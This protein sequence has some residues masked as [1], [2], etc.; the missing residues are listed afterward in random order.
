MEQLEENLAIAENEQIP[1]CQDTGM[2]VVF[3]DFTANHQTYSLPFSI[4]SANPF[5]LLCCLHTAYISQNKSANLEELLQ[6]LS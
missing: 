3:P 4:I 1:I 2:A 5:D 6:E